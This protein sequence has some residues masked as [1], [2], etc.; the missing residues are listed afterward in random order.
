[1]MQNVG[2]EGPVIDV[3]GNKWYKN[4]LLHREDGPAIEYAGGKRKWYQNGRLHRDG[5]PAVEKSDGTVEYRLE[6]FQV[7][8]LMKKLE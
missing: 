2:E 7:P 8:T 4:G 6:D 5:G 1:M 3:E